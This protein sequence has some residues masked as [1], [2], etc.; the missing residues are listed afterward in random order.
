MVNSTELHIVR[1]VPGEGTG[2]VCYQTHDGRWWKPWDG[3]DK[4]GEE[5]RKKEN[6]VMK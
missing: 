6:N 2:D 3:I 4:T 1:E 5:V